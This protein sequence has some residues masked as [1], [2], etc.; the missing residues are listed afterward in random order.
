MGL[1][2]GGVGLQCG[3]VGLQCGGVGVSVRWGLTH[4]SQNRIF[5]LE[6]W[7]FSRLYSYLKAVGVVLNSVDYSAVGV[8][9]NSANYSA[10]GVVVNSANYSAVG[11][12][13]TRT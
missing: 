13:I 5:S 4:C 10:V 12:G 1:Q 9:V 2:C 7:S 11:V 3:G 8:G 6:W